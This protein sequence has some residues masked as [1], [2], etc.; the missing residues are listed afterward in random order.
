[1]AAVDF[2]ADSKLVVRN[3]LFKTN[4]PSISVVVAVIIVSANFYAVCK[5]KSAG[6][7]DNEFLD[8]VL[9]CEQ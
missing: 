3:S 9:R 4:T 8:H 2:H 1:M 7:G 5:C 6:D